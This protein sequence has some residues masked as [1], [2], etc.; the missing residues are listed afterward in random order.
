MAEKKARMPFVIT[1]GSTAAANNFNNAVT[2]FNASPQ[3]VVGLTNCLDQNVILFRKRNGQIIAQGIGPVIAILTGPAPNG[4]AGAQFAPVSA[5]Y[6]PLALPAKV[7][8]E[9]YWEDND[10]TPPDDIKFEFHFN[11]TNSLISTLWAQ[12]K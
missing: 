2:A 10:G 4:L 6:S 5:D 8:G 9:A 1:A 3:D 12:T 7:K 11:T